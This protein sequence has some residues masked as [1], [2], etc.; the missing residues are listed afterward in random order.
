M[1][2]LQC[3]NTCLFNTIDNLSYGLNTSFA[4]DRNAWNIRYLL[5]LVGQCE[6]I[7]HPKSRLSKN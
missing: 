1:C 7:A 5:R 3:M 4:Y 6:I 2:S